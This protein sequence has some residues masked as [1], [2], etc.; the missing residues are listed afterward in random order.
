M[1]RTV[2][3]IEHVGITVPDLEEATRFFVDAFGAEVLYD[4][5]PSAPVGDAEA[6]AGEQA[7]LGTRD[8]VRWLGSTLLRVGEG[9]TIELFEYE[10]REQAPPPTASDLGIQ[11]FAFYVDDI[12]AARASVLAAG[13]RALEGPTLL[14]G[15]ESGDGNKWLYVIAPWGG[16]IELV[17]FPSPQPYEETTPLRR[18]RPPAR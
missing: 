1:S 8:G 4:L 5:L 18:W 16:I 2:R 10:D 12:D 3:G 9:P 7:R 14:P 15:L 11:H 13:G 17:T 6:S